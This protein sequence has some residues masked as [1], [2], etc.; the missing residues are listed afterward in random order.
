MS[1]LVLKKGNFAEL[2]TAMGMQG[3]TSDKSKLGKKISTLA[4]LKLLSK[5]LI[6]CLNFAVGSVAV[7]GKSMSDMQKLMGMSE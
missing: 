2:A 5:Q 1:D 3:E 6:E 4:R 7:Q